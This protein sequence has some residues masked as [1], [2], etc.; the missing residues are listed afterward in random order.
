MR[1]PHLTRLLLGGLAAVL[2]VGLLV[3]LLTGDKNGKLQSGLLLPQARALTTWGEP[4]QTTDGVSFALEDFKGRPH[5][6]FFGF[7]ACPDIC[8]STLLTVS[9][10]FRQLP[11]DAQAQLQVTF[12]SVDPDRDTPDMLRQYVQNFHP[13][14][15]A[16]TGPE[17]SLEDLASQAGIAYMKV[18]LDNGYTIDHSAALVYLDNQ[19]RIRAYFAPPLDVDK[20][21]ADLNQLVDRELR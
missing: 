9:Q 7:A 6:L 15:Q 20:L 2:L 14:F 12:I 19:A 16:L 13:R 21:T 4:L 1:R 11:S 17:S 18:P 3:P 10:M 8:P 5:L